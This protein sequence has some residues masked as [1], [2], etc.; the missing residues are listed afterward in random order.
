MDVVIPVYYDYASTL[1]YIAWR[2]VGELERELGFK[3]LWKGVPI[4]LRLGMVRSGRALTQAERAK[5]MMVAAETGVDVVIPERWVDSQLALEG[6]E[7][8]REK[9]V[10]DA[11]HAAVFDAFCQHG[12]DISQPEVLVELAQHVGL[13]PRQFLADLLSHRMAP[14]LLTHK[15]EADRFSAVGY[16]S[17]LLGEFALIGVQHID[18][19]R[20][21]FKRFI[22]LRSQ[23][24]LGN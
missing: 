5:I 7:I 21:L 19:M 13:E 11:Y 15:L 17:F 4:A 24:E 20:L 2:I 9:G 1:C 6:A 12:R 10:F 16:P 14:R 23:Q 8:A 18:T 3:A 22:E